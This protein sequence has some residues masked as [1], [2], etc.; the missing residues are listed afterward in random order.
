LLEIRQQENS[1]VNLMAHR[2]LPKRTHEAISAH[3][4]RI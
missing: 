1:D 4:N 3:K 2:T